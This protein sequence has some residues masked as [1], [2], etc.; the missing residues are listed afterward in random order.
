MKIKCKGGYKITTYPCNVSI[1]YTEVRHFT[2]SK[3]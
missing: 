3:F 1:T 2:L